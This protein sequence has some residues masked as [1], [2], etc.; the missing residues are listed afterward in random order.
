M[1]NPV[2][3]IVLIGTD[4]R[5]SDKILPHVRRKIQKHGGELVVIDNA[6]TEA[7]VI[8]ASRDA[9]GLLYR[10][11]VLPSRRILEA[12]P[13]CKIIAS[14]RV[15]FPA[16][17]DTA[18]DNGIIITNVPDVSTNTVADHAMA[19]LLASYRGLVMLDRKLR[20]GVPWKAAKGYEYTLP[21]LSK[22][23]LG[24][25]GFGRIGQSVAKRAKAFGMKVIAYSR[26]LDAASVAKHGV[27]TVGMDD[28]LRHSD[29]VSFR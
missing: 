14:I 29:I 7:E 6:T 9:D 20:N 28:L 24:L 13:R 11:G 22:T 17:C 19:H 25:I 2:F 1:A 3:R 12:L 26:S 8:A 5:G 10:C 21:Q 4:F 18:T 16:D 27:E 15:G 23:T